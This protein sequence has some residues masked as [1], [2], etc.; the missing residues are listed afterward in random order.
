M[1]WKNYRQCGVVPWKVAVCRTVPGGPVGPQRQCLSICSSDVLF[2][3]PHVT[4][5]FAGS[6][7]TG[8]SVG[9]WSCLSGVVRLACFSLSILRDEIRASHP[10]K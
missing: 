8:L 3:K 5:P 10:A 1:A 4:Q 7:E 2:V 9:L 6:G